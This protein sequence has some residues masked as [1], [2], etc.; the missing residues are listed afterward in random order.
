MTGICNHSWSLQSIKHRCVF[1]FYGYTVHFVRIN[2]RGIERRIN[3]TIIDRVDT[4][5]S[6]VLVWHFRNI[7][8]Y[9]CVVHQ[10]Y[11]YL[12]RSMHDCESHMITWRSWII[13]RYKIVDSLIICSDIAVLDLT[14]LCYYSVLLMSVDPMYLCMNQS[15]Q[16][17]SVRRCM[18]NGVWNGKDFE[19]TGVNF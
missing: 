2:R 3:L 19:C 6:V 16:G 10:I 5:S 7:L 1:L 12:K 11:L 8:C 9:G 17:S 4:R 13:S 14:S 18:E 15:T